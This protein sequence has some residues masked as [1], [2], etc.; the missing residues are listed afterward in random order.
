MYLLLHAVGRV[1]VARLIPLA[2]T[3]HVS[4]RCA[5]VGVAGW[6]LVGPQRAWVE[7]ATDRPGM[8]REPLLTRYTYRYVQKVLFLF[9][10]GPG[11]DARKIMKLVK[12]SI[13][14]ENTRFPVFK[15][16]EIND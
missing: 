6:C 13:D 1:V 2:A 5:T 16:A 11:N 12:E 8:P 10:K 14:T 7:L 15:L 4:A 9:S 3:D